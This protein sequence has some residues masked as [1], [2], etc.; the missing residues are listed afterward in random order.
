MIHNFWFDLNSKTIQNLWEISKILK[1]SYVTLKMIF[2]SFLEILVSF[3]SFKV[4]FVSFCRLRDFEQ[5]KKKQELFLYKEQFRSQYHTVSHYEVFPWNVK[6]LVK[7]CHKLICC[8][9]FLFFFLPPL[10]FN[11]KFIQAWPG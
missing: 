6:K 10:H 1:S 3:K 4:I 8:C 5:G 7:G 9:Y 11:E 2:D